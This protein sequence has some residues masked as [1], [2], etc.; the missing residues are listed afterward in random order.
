MC[1]LVSCG[2]VEL[3]KRCMCVSVCVCVFG[4]ACIYIGCVCIL[5][6]MCVYKYVFVQVRG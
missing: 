5:G 6:C 4:C 2:G 3:G 1:V